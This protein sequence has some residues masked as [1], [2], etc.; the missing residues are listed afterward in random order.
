MH[1]YLHIGTEK[2][3]TT[4]IQDFLHLNAE[5]LESLG[6]AYL[7]SAGY[8]NNL[9]LV[10][11]AYEL[12]R[13]DR[14]TANKKVNTDADMVQLQTNIVTDMREELATKQVKSLIISS[15]HIQARLTSYTEL[16]RLKSILEGLGVTGFSVIL[17]I[18]DPAQAAA[19]L[20]S[21]SIKSGSKKKV[22][23]LPKAP[24]YNLICNHKKTI[25]LFSSVFGDFTLKIR[26]FDKEFL[27]NHSVLDDF[28]SLL[29]L[30]SADEFISPNAENKSLSKLGLDLLRRMNERIPNLDQRPR[31]L[32]RK[33]ILAH[34][35]RYFSD[36]KYSLSE[37][38]YQAYE[39][40]FADSNEWVRQ[41]F[42]PERD[43]LF[44]MRANPQ[45]ND[46]GFTDK[47]LDSLANMLA[48]IWLEQEKDL[49]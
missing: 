17:Y 33:K 35:E 10:V 2:T 13:R 4:L 31:L 39:E 7:R 34:F 38:I 14:W 46:L 32:L 20:Y 36:E 1:C 22:P 41:R 9:W 47:D 37:D 45:S 8:P 30:D 15:E 40:A 21:T 23:H 44:P 3:G 49:S 19:S 28:L 26:L 6:L 48:D 43:R 16:L 42:F 24:N 11:A 29:N 27:L 5:K 12:E 18:R 25:E